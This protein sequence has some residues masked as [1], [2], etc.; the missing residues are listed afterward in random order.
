MLLELSYEISLQEMKDY[1]REHTDF[2]LMTLEILSTLIYNYWESYKDQITMESKG[3][4]R[5]SQSVALDAFF[6]IINHL[7]DS[8]PQKMPF[9]LSFYLR[10][11]D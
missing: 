5:V 7:A 6:K 4:C 8:N 3:L 2:N 1:I 9:S 11:H 10:D